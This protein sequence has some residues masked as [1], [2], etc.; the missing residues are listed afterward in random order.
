MSPPIHVKAIVGLVQ[1]TFLVLGLRDVFS[2]ATF[3]FPDDEKLLGAVFGGAGTPTQAFMGVLLVTLACAKLTT[4]FSNPEGTFL[5]R[6][7]LLVFGAL[8]LF[9]TY[10]IVTNMNT[11]KLAEVDF[12]PWIGVVGLEGAVL[13]QDGAM[14][15]R[16][17]KKGKKK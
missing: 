6:N 14:R 10:V 3:V 4:V 8:D 1:G 9:F 12:K 5:R 7:L 15:D 11:G 17:T 13:L 16:S 2:P